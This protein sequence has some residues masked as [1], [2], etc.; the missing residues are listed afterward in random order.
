MT[1][2]LGFLQIALE[3]PSALSKEHINLMIDELLRA[4]G[5]ITEFLTLAKNRKHDLCPTE[6]NQIVKNIMPLIEAEANLTDKN[7]LFELGNVPKLLLD[8]KE[9]RQMILNLSLN[10]LEAMGQGG[11]L[12]IKTYEKSK[13]VILEVKD[14]GKGIRSKD[15][16][17][18]GT[19]FFTTKDTGTGLGLAICYSI[20]NRHKAQISVDTGRKGTTFY[21]KFPIEG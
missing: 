7:V 2:V 17:K 16:D 1:S 15:L 3:N 20:A 11:Q 5:I 13:E 9:I 10:G 14:Q 21:V 12:T 6:L 8:E 4:N 18:I 19:P